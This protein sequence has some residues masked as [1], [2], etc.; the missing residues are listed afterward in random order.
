MWQLSVESNDPL[1]NLGEIDPIIE[2][3]KSAIKENDIS[4]PP[5]IM[6]RAINGVE[7]LESVGMKQLQEA[8]K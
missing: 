6:L 3:I 8:L 4:G 1:D 2:Q 7:G 5:P